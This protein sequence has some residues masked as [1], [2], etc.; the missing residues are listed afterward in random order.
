MTIKKIKSIHKKKEI[1]TY[2]R[3]NEVKAYITDDKPCEGTLV[4]EGGAFRGLYTAG[5]LD[6]LLDNDININTVVGISAGALTGLNYLAGARGRSALCILK[7]R[8]ESRYVGVKAIQ[9]SGSIVGFKFM[10]ED[11]DDEFPIDNTRITRGDKKLYAGCTNLE[12]GKA[13]F[14][15]TF[16]L[17]KMKSAVKAS[18]SMPL[19]SRIVKIDNKKYLDGGCETKLPIKYAI[20]NNFEKIIFVATRPLSYRRKLKTSELKVEKVRYKNYPNFIKALSN[21]N[22][23]YNLDAEFLENLANRKGILAI[24]PSEP[25][26]VS[27]LE[28]D[29]EK[30]GNLYMLGYEDCKKRLPEIKEYLEI[31]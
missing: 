11:L 4:L 31:K 12:T 28:K 14:I 20:E 25:V 8:Y 9:E 7:H 13:E 21:A 19:V 18:A 30:L 24:S 5:V 29:I 15:Q 26:D 16:N 22:K 6:C 17:D 10:F 2:S 27:R 23:R 3:I 1:P